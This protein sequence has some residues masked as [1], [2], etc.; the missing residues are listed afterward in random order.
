MNNGS[1]GNE[2]NEDVSIVQ[3]MKYE[4]GENSVSQKN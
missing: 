1:A 3:I 2:S 4:A